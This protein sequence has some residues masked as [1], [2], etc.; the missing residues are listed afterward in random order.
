MLCTGYLGEQIQA[1]FGSAFEGMRLAHSQEPFPL[2]TGGALKL[3]LAL[4][5]SESVLVMNGDSFCD[6][7]LGALWAQHSRRAA[8][9][10][11][12]LAE[13]QDG[14]RYGR[15][16]VDAEGRVRSFQEK[17]GTERRGFISAGVYCLKRT[18]VESIPSAVAVS[19]EHE[20]F[21]QWV[22]RGL[23]GYYSRGRFLDIGT[24]E[25]YATAEQFFMV[26]SL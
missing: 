18:L 25:S 10:T 17:A 1:A 19:L 12:L 20:V 13:M 22:G 15:V 9:A 21:P 26:N 2:G 4:M 5:A 16:A 23:E 11:L 24:P 3:A 14:S 8:N 7:D 6:A